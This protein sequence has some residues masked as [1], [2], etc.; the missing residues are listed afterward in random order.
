MG[1]HRSEVKKRA[2]P[3]RPAAVSHREKCGGSDG[4][5]PDSLIDHL[6]EKHHRLAYTMD[7]WLNT[8]ECNNVD[9]LFL[10]SGL[11]LGLIEVTFPDKATRPEK[12]K[13]LVTALDDVGNLLAS[14]VVLSKAR[15]G[16][17]PMVT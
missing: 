10:L 9:K 14:M 5:V 8:R 6:N 4:L 16:D 11:V 13:A 1:T 12:F 3:K 2:H 15:P 17:L 7:A